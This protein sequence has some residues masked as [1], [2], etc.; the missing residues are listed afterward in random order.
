MVETLV[1]GIVAGLIGLGLADMVALRDG[2]LGLF[3]RVR[4]LMTRAWMPA[5][6][7]ENADCVFCWAF[8]ESLL[9]AWLVTMNLGSALLVPWLMGFGLA[10]FL[11]KYVGH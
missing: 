9:G 2:P 1:E 6:V 5:W 11:F 4:Q 3:R 8:Y 10:V 7:R